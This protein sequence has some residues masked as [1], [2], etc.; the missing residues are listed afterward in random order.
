MAP[1]NTHERVAAGARVVDA[2]EWE[3]RKRGRNQIQPL[4]DDRHHSRRSSSNM[5]AAMRAI[6]Q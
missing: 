3:Q 5:W 1:S 6:P 4:W 2:G